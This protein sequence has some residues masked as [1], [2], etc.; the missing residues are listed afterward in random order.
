MLKIFKF[1]LKLSQ[2]RKGINPIF[3]FWTKIF[4]HEPKFSRIS[5][6]LKFK[7]KG[8]AYRPSATLA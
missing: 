4:R 5:D 6:G 2:R 7:K 3:A 8:I 1:D